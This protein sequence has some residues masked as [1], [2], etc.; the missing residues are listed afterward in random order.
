MSKAFSSIRFY[1]IV[2]NVLTITNYTGFSISEVSS[3]TPDDARNF[4]F[5]NGID[6]YQHPNPRMYKLGLQ[7][8][9]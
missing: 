7:L 9:F 6:F 8:N 2:Q 5:F 4:I 1:A 3:S